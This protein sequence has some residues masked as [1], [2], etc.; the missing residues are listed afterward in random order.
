[1]GSRA[2]CYVDKYLWVEYDILCMVFVFNKASHMDNAHW[3]VGSPFDWLVPYVEP[4]KRLCGRFDGCVFPIHECMFFKMGCILPF[5]DRPCKG[6]ESFKNA[7]SQ[8]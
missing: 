4:E 1:M 2:S 5:N 8:L 7:P 3:N 6:C